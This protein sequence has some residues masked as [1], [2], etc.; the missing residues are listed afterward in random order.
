MTESER[1]GK[2]EVIKSISRGGQGQVYLVRDSSGLPNTGE[3]WKT[4]K[5]AIETL[6]AGIDEW[7]YEQAASELADEIRR[8]V[9]ESQATR[10]ALKKLLPIEEGAAED[11]AAALERM[12]QELSTLESVDHPALVKVLDRNLDEEWFVMEFLEGGTLSNRLEKYKGRALDALATF[13]PIVDAAVA[14]HARE[15]VH[16]DIKPDNIFV[17][18]DGHLVLGD[19]G[20]AFGLE[21]DTRQTRPFENVGSR[22]FQPPWSYTTRLAE[23]RTQ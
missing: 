2:W 17:A 20:L 3:Q 12:K 7:H 16:R 18:S 10:G 15:V 13:R 23:V 4:F 1:Y 19:C 21:H 11:E 22:D 5:C 9:S 6:N 14:L 8:I